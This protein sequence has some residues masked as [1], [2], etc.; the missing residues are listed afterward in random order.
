MT[1]FQM[2]KSLSRYAVEIGNLK[3]KAQ[4]LLRYALDE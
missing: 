1:D 4:S 2:D 3:N